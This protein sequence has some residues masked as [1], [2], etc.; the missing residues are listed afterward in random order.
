MS[1]GNRS[2]APPHAGPPADTT[3]TGSQTTGDRSTIAS[4]D[5]PYQLLPP[6]TGDEYAALRE[7]IAA[8]GIRVPV[9]VDEDGTVLDGHHRQAIAAEL[10]IPCPTRVV[11]GLTD[12]DKRCHALAVNLQ[13]RTLT[14]EQ[15][16]AL[17]LAELEHDDTRSDRAIARL[18][19]CDH[20][21]VGAVR[22]VL[23]AP[24]GGGEIPH[25][26][27][28]AEMLHSPDYGPW[29][30]HPFLA[31]FP[32]IPVDQFADMVDSIRRMGLLKQ[33]TIGPDGKTLVDGRLRYLACRAA[34]VEPSYRTLGP[35]YTPKMVLDFIWSMNMMR[36]SYTR[37]QV[38]AITVTLAD[39]S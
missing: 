9:D 27:D 17:I 18:L 6:L 34:A 32:L 36:Q 20:K 37:D 15:R 31:A 22:A 14:R 39:A 29:E 12:E 21:T 35:H 10:G 33:I 5:T 1:R 23:T 8:N 19:G 30:I 38:A 11:T 2:P 7:D 4:D 28:P 13:R 26:A 16:R 3:T 24:R 25:P